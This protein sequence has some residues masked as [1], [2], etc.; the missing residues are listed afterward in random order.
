M[1]DFG[2]K[3]KDN[4]LIALNKI[5]ISQLVSQIIFFFTFD[6]KRMG[7]SQKILIRSEQITPRLR[8]VIR[9]IFENLLGVE[10]VI[11]RSDEVTD[12][13]TLPIISYTYQPGKGGGMHIVPAG[14][15]FQQG[16][17]PD[18]HPNI[19]YRDQIPVIFGSTTQDSLGFDIF[20]AI[21]YVLSRYEEYISVHFDSHR[22]FQPDSSPFFAHKLYAIPVADEWVLLLKNKLSEHYPHLSFK[23]QSY[24]YLPTIDVD[25][26]Y[27]YRF[28]KLPYTVGGIAKS[29]LR[30]DYYSLKTRL[31]ALVS[32]K[33]DPYFTFDYLNSVTAQHSIQ[34]LYFYLC[35]G[36]KP[37]DPIAGY[38]KRA[39]QETVKFNQQH[40]LAGL[41]NSYHTL[42]KPE[43]I[44]KELGQ[45]QSMIEEP[46]FRSRFHFIR[47]QIP[48]SY[49][50][51]L[52]A[53]I[54]EDYSMGFPSINGFRSGTS[55]PFYFYDLS[56]E[57]ETDLKIFPF[58]AM[59]ATYIHYLKF[60]PDE[61]YDD[62]VQIREQVR[63][64]NGTFII[65][66][67]NNY[68]EPTPL[69]QHWRK[70]FEAMLA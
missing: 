20:S 13:T 34:P 18:L 63:R 40:A 46:I 14:L 10:P 67:H 59:D 3:P 30:K 33:E 25:M 64:H 55:H 49:Q 4:Q 17:N 68:F 28:K 54:R 11:V 26:P 47:F 57:E 35:S 38:R 58:Q 45:L 21:F 16:I 31:Q 39:V 48:Q 12:G 41:H 29:I 23:K 24:T 5:Q 66:W 19:D 9:H 15:L 37:Y 65:I 52:Q 60:T 2:G 69:G 51:L 32:K 44:T 22:R 42:D 70:V 27:A 61:A 56:R 8:Y 6:S 36:Q 50:Q 62:L 53:G 7:F 1:R 43:L